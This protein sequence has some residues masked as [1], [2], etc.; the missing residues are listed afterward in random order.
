MR[1]LVLV[2][3]ML[4]IAGAVLALPPAKESFILSAG[5]GTGSGTTQWRTDVWIYNPSTTQKATV[6]VFFLP[7][8]SGSAANTNPTSRRVEVNA[9]ATREL[10]A[11]PEP[12]FGLTGVQLRS[13]ALRFRPRRRGDGPHL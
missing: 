8:T 13:P 10:A 6:D 3:V 11:D 2:L 12:N 5:Q 4:A 7:R 1:K 9:G